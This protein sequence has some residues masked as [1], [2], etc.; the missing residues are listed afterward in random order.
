MEKT[1]G[2]VIFVTYLALSVVQL[3]AFMEGLDTWLG[4]GNI[5]SVAIFVV[6]FM[7][8]PI[9]GIAIAVVGFMGATN[10]WGWEWWQ[11]ALLCFP[12]VILSFLSMGTSSILSLFSKSDRSCK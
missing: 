12:F 4:F 1:L 7:L 11:A 3:V 10:G 5:A 2:S 8:G 9:G 6:A